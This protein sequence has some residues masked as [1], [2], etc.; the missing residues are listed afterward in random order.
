MNKIVFDNHIS[1]EKWN[2]LQ[3]EATFCPWFQ[4][5]KAFLFYKNTSTVDAFAVGVE[6]D[7]V[8]KC[9]TVGYIQKEG[10]AIKQFFSKRAVILGGPLL[11]KQLNAE[12]LSQMLDAVKKRLEGKAIYIEFRFFSNY[13]Q[14]VNVFED[15]DFKYQQHYD[16]IV[17]T[18]NKDDVL[19]KMGKS[20]KRD[21]KLSLREG[22]RIIQNPTPKQ[23]KEYYAVLS[24]LYRTKVK[25]PLFPLSFF[26]D[27]SNDSEFH[28][29]LVEYQGKI[30]GGTVCVGAKGAVLY[31]MYACG[32]DG[33]YKNVFPS[34]LATYAA[35]EYAFENGYASLDMMGAGKPNDG[36]YGVRDFK[37]KFG[38]DLLEYGRSIFICNF[39]LYNLGKFVVNLIKRL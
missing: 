23:V 26:E 35:I 28:L 7:G 8:L 6:N 4:T 24:N 12:E 29:F 27:L 22:A 39:Y 3:N 16:I 1:E 13:K 34:E 30:I 37:L 19:N 17:N 9:L 31:E 32:I 2:S 38:G 33:V 15:Q 18:K 20:R 25:T 10:G 14:W 5:Y 21:I 36:G 11:H